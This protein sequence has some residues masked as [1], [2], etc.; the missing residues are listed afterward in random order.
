ME[1]MS[2]S[3]TPS[4][5]GMP[6]KAHASASCDRVVSPCGFESATATSPLCAGRLAHA[7][8]SAA[9]SGSVRMWNLEL[10]AFTSRLQMKPITS[11]PAMMYMVTL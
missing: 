1:L 9:Q 8:A 11:N 10:T 3:I 2:V 4:A 7:A 5:S 6:T